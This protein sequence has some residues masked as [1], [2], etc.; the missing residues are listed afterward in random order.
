MGQVAHRFV[1]TVVDFWRLRPKRF[2]LKRDQDPSRYLTPYEFLATSLGLGFTMYV[3]TISL[4]QSEVYKATGDQ[5]GTSVEALA[6]RLLAYLV[7][8]LVLNSILFRAISRV[9]PVR[10]RATFLSIFQFQC[11]TLAIF[12]PGMALDLLFTPLVVA[13]ILR[14]IIPD[15]SILVL[16]APIAGIGL[17]GTL[18]W[19]FPGVAFLNG[20]STR[21]LWA[22]YLF[23]PA[24]LG[25]VL[26]L[27]IVVLVILASLGYFAS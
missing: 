26:G 11:Y 17:V 16:I 6:T 21:R 10:G 25:A 24:A 8:V 20:V 14:K 18:F 9:W 22:G 19:E 4:I 13:G 23:W 27:L 12:L 1:T 3:A 5:D 2:L 7:A 15:W